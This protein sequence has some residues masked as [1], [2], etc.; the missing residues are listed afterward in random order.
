MQEIHEA[1]HIFLVELRRAVDRPR[2]GRLL[3]RNE[4]D[5]LIDFSLVIERQKLNLRNLP[6]N[7]LPDSL[8]AIF[9][10]VVSHVDDQPPLLSIL[11]KTAMTVQFS[12]SA[13]ARWPVE[14]RNFV[15]SIRGLQITEAL[16][17][18]RA[19][20]L[21]GGTSDFFDLMGEVSEEQS[22]SING[23]RLRT[24]APTQRLAPVWFDVVNG[25]IVIIDQ[26]ASAGLDDNTPLQET[27][28][29]LMGE[30][31]KVLSELQGSNCDRRLVDNFRQLTE[32]LRV[33]DNP[34]KLG[35]MNITSSFMTIQFKDELPDAVFAAMSGVTQNISM[36]VAQFPEWVTFS[37][38]AAAAEID[39]DVV[40]QIRE[41]AEKLASDLESAPDLADPEVPRTIRLLEEAA[42][43][44]QIAGKRAIFALV[45]T[46]ENL[47]S[48][49]ARFGG[50]IISDTASETKRRVSKTIG[51]GIAVALFAATINGAS[52]LLPA[53][54]RLSE[55]AWL[56]PAL[57]I[58]QKEI[59][60]L[61]K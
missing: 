18:A 47:V 24:L 39:G 40:S 53:A 12:A 22:S 57:E 4:R 3:S 14:V 20:F 45:R 28:D 58:M 7:A 29:F 32:Q 11:D 25:R 26:P 15:N 23:Q 50:E 55:L 44:P 13:E 5:Q 27:H 41:S 35:A 6:K 16:S 37:E 59:T 9:L 17:L 19:V 48:A 52:A 42:T 21:E 36:Y 1:L 10:P 46:L 33:N 31:E 60:R 49:V 30:S 2:G 38:N 51:A 34:I 61:P 43:S 56:R 8:I 54:E